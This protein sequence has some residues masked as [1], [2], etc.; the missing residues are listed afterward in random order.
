VDERSTQGDAARLVEDLV[1]R[2][3]VRSEA[4]RHAFLAVPRHPFVPGVA[5]D[6]AYR[7]D[8]AIPTHF[9]ER[10]ISISSSSA[11][12]IMAVMLELLT[13]APGHR[14]LEIGA[15]T[16][17][18]AAL[19][20][21]LVGNTGT[22]T[23]LD[24]DEIVADEARAH[25]AEVGAEGVAV[26]CK[27]GWS[28][29]DAHAPFDRIIATVECWDVS[30]HWA[31]QLHEGGILVLPL[32]LGPGLT[33]AVAFE[34]VGQRLESTAMAYC[35]FMPLR[36]PHA[37]PE[38]RALVSRWDTTPSGGRQESKWLAVLPDAT[39]ARCDALRALLAS[40]V[41]RTATASGLVAGWN[42]RLVLEERDP[43]FLFENASM[44]PRNLVG[45]FDA[46]GGS[47]ALVE[48]GSISGFGAASC[49]ERIAARLASS[50][51]LDLLAL[52]ITA[53]PH[54]RD[55]H[56]EGDVVLSRPHFDLV[57]EGLR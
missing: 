47:L 3:A 30:P 28:G 52:R 36:G 33:M 6:E 29:E 26:L 22:V 55:H 7:A 43:I 39:Q 41:T 16:G 9:D 35:G 49:F 11:P 50:E 19:L 24:I 42:V 54:G 12:A 53:T 31:R 21:R 51:P 40:G 18:N 1:A 4:V 8:R 46:D 37:G 44:A 34:K 48:D 27:D 56:G 13:V 20:A 10:G 17:Y 23:S 14:V 45:L 32:A 38:R 5:P 2:R 15:G 25:L 57:V